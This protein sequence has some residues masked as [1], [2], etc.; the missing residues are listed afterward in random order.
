MSGCCRLR[1]ESPPRLEEEDLMDFYFY[2]YGDQDDLFRG[3]FDVCLPELYSTSPVARS[4]DQATI[5]V[6]DLSSM[7]QVPG[8]T[9]PSPDP[10]DFMPKSAG[11]FIP[12]SVFTPIPEAVSNLDALGIARVCIWCHCV[13][14]LLWC[15]LWVSSV[16]SCW[17]FCS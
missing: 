1:F 14:G 5:K 4:P 9:L 10:Q 11:S 6:P 17:R 8:L 16:D 2:F 7:A 3:S 15:S 12:D 13:L